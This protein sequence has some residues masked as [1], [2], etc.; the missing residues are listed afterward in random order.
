[1]P[2]KVLQQSENIVEGI[3][4]RIL[5]VF[6]KLFIILSCDVVCF[7]VVRTVSSEQYDKQFSIVNIFMTMPFLL[8]LALLY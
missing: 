2:L 7:H 4:N 6:D 8:P 3:A 1:M 5:T